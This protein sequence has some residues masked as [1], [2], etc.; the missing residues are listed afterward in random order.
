MIMAQ[1]IEIKNLACSTN[2]QVTGLDCPDCAAK[3]EKA[4]KRIPG[5]ASATV[6]FPLGK[7]RVDYDAT[8]TGVK[9]VIDKVRVLGYD[10]EEASAVGS[11]ADNRRKMGYTGQV[12]KGI[13]T[14]PEAVSFWKSNQYAI[15]TVISFVMLLFGLITERMA[16][17][18]LV[19]IAFFV[20]G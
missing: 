17:P 11:N 8:Q 5:V 2:F 7:L 16:V 14:R 12:D 4:I 13:R 18:T 3:V 19:P 20:T 6:A 1:A 10:A 9:Q 15:P